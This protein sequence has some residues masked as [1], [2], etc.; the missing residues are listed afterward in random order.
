MFVK[1][2]KIKKYIY[3]Y[4]RDGIG[5]RRIVTYVPLMI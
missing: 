4:K 1:T 5:V 2:I 3:I